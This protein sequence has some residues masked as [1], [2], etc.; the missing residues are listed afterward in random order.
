M[1]RVRTSPFLPHR[2]DVRGFVYDVTTGALREVP[3]TA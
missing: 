2:D 3:A 1:A